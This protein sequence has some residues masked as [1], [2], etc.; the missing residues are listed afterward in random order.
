MESEVLSQPI[1]WLPEELYK[2]DEKIKRT[3]LND[4]Q[5]LGFYFASLTS[6]QCTNFTPEL[7]NFYNKFNSEN[8]KVFEVI[9]FSNDKDENAFRQHYDKM[10]W[11]ACPFKCFEQECIDEGCEIN[12]LPTLIVFSKNGQLI[13]ESGQITLT[14]KNED[15]TFALW[16]SKY[17]H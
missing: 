1:S 4:V 2:Q 15:D 6:G 11:L 12:D 13:D 17:D 7:I 16:L 3:E 10:P 8:N 14:E 9:F 5:L